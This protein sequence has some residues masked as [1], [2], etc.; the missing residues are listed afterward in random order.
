MSKLAK[1]RRLAP[2]DRRLLIEASLLLLV[3]RAA[4]SLLPFRTVVSAVSSCASSAPLDEA[5]ALALVRR[6]RWAVRAATRNGPGRAVCFPQGIAAHIMLSRRGMPSRLYYG[7]AK[8]AA[9][10]LDAHV[11]V[12]AGS[13]AVIGCGA[14]ARFALMTAFPRDG[15]VSGGNAP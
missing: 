10:A 1:L 4:L 12:R 13:L 7:V 6:V 8:T 15:A 9:G 11:W 2:C 14:A 3:A 5:A